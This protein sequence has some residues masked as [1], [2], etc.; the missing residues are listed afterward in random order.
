MG[1]YFI[2]HNGVEGV[3][4]EALSS[5]RE[6]P[7]ISGAWL[8]EGEQRSAEGWEEEEYGERSSFSKACHIP[9]PGVPRDGGGG[10][11]GV[12]QSISRP[13]LSLRAIWWENLQ[14]SDEVRAKAV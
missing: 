13:Q 6:M 4:A 2:L 3:R 12:G 8:G 14:A 7:G 11:G 9:P 10:E 1:C 5:P